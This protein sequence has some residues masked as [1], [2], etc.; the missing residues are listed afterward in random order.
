M[1][2]P[3]LQNIID[4]RSKVFQDVFLVIFFF[5]TVFI[6]SYAIGLY[7]LFTNFLD[8]L[9]IKWLNHLFI[10]FIFSFIPF[11]AFALRRYVDLKEEI[12]NRLEIQGDYKNYINQ[13]RKVFES[14][15]DFVLQTDE[16]LRVIWAN[17]KALEQFNQPIGS[18][19]HKFLFSSEENLAIDNYIQKALENGSIE[20][21]VK[22]YPGH[23]DKDK[24][25][26]LEHI[27]IPFKNKNGEIIGI[28]LISRD[29]TE[30]IEFEES[31]SRLASIVESSEDAIFVV[32]LDGSI[33]SWNKSAENIFGYKASQ[34]VGQQ[35][36]ILDHII[37]FETLIKIP[38]LNTIQN[39]GRRILHID[40][41]AVHRKDQTIYV[42]L[43]VYPFV[44]EKGQVLGFTTIARDITNAI[45]AEEAL[46]ES[47]ERYRTFV[48]NFKGIAF[49]WS[50]EYIP[51]FM[52]GNV[53]EITGY[54]VEEFLSNKIG[55]NEII[56]KDD[57]PLVL[58]NRDFIKKNPNESIEFE[59]RIQTKNSE[60]RWLNESLLN[61]SNDKNEIIFI[62]ATIYDITQ[63]KNAETQLRES[64]Q[65]LRNLALHLDSVREEERKQI[66]FEIHDELG[67]ALTAIK[68]DIAWLVKK[69]DTSKD[70]LEQKIKEMTDLLELTIQKVRTISSQL[71]P[72]I[73]DHFGLV[74]AIDWQSKEFQRRT[75]I[76]T[77]FN[78]NPKDIYVPENLAT[79]IFRIF[80][81]S[82]TN[83]SRYAKASR[84]DVFLEKQ[85]QNI[86]LKVVDNGVGID[87]EMIYHKNSFGLLGMREKAKSMGGEVVINNLALKYKNN[88]S[89]S[90]EIHGTEVVLSVPIKGEVKND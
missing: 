39:E 34:V 89:N 23:S 2:K 84:V 50:P 67:Y 70:N 59:Y 5:I 48:T 1:P 54:E 71:R 32:S 53:H 69:I 37:D 58:K 10:A 12:N 86:I 19:I 43:T 55:W 44:D 82:L 60:I 63:R 25:K 62:Q 27:A 31:R 76:R 68:L 47:E 29:I 30:K 40:M 14:M 36:T 88:G 66:A 41:V 16:N 73:L 64:R 28:T 75:A 81:E 38:Q 13:M 65:Q 61:V 51:I 52:H 26:Y 90:E 15:G 24:D 80:Q 85:D 9:K 8:T 57:L 74:A 21:Q 45:K 87:P 17:T 35:I 83:I 72:S 46:R 42:S 79:P 20:R 4:Y 33:H 56:L 3:V 7:D 78:V 22:F 6:I 49:R 11:L 18:S 77:R